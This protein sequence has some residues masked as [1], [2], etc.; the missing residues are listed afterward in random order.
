[1][2]SSQFLNQCFNTTILLG[3]HF[4]Q[5]GDGEFGLVMRYIYAFPSVIVMSIFQV[6]AGQVLVRDGTMTIRPPFA[7]YTLLFGL[8]VC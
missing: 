4:V 6:V 2:C 1:M 3:V 8:R 7:W 5:V